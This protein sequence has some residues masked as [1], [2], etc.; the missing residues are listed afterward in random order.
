MESKISESQN[1]EPENYLSSVGLRRYPDLARLSSR[2]VARI[3]IVERLKPTR[4]AKPK[5]PKVGDLG[6]G[7]SLLP[8]DRQMESML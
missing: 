8:P 5:G 7:S 1:V 3:F 6:R 2:D 4:S